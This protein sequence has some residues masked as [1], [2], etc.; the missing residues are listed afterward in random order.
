MDNLSLSHTTRETTDSLFGGAIKVM[1]EKNGYRFSID[2]LLLG[3]FVWLRKGERVI[4]LG[5]GVGII[6]LI[7]GK[8][9]NGALEIVGVEVQEKLAKLARRNVHINGFNGLITIYHGDIKTLKNNFSASSFDV[10]VTNPPYYRVASGRI[11][12]HNQ[13]AIARHEITCTID[14]ILGAAS[15]LLRTGGRIFVIFPANRSI[16][17]FNCLRAVSLEPKKLRWVHSRRGEGAK[18]ALVE[19]YKTRGEGVEVL[20]PLFI[21]SHQ[22]TYSKE[23]ERLYS[24]ATVMRKGE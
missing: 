20:P 8:R 13:K 18:F 12:P 21:Y 6:P 11:N 22:G 23:L 1:Q 9:G 16:T 17:L 7:L 3:G 24:G 4:D 15:Y 5:T 14:D 19:A 2:A 10:V